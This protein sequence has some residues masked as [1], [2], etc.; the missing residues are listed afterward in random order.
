MARCPVCGARA[1]YDETECPGCGAELG[2]SLAVIEL[3]ESPPAPG[4]PRA[5]EPRSPR[6]RVGVVA[7]VIAAVLAV[8]AVVQAGGG[9]SRRPVRRAGGAARPVFEDA[10][11]VR[12][13]LGSSDGVHLVDLDTGRMRTISPAIP[14]PFD[15]I[16]ALT[17]GLV[18]A[19]GTVAVGCVGT[20]PH[21]CDVELGNAVNVY[22]GPEPD[23]VWAVR[24]TLD[25]RL[26]VA[27]LGLTGRTGPPIIVLR[28]RTTVAAA[29]DSGFVL[30]SGTTLSLWAR[31]VGERLV[32]TDAR[33]VAARGSLVAWLGRRC[34][35][36]GCPL[37]LT[38]LRANRD[39]VIN[40][41]AES[42]DA[43]SGG[44]FAPD[45]HTLAIVLDLHTGAQRMLALV[46]VDSGFVRLVG[47]LPLVASPD[48]RTLAWAP[49]GQVVFA[50]LVGERLAAIR[51]D[52]LVE[53][54]RVP[55]P[56]FVALAA[57][58]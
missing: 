8:A 30:V 49:S 3:D 55:L 53:L 58:G 22:A 23:L 1:S 39:R 2:D 47:P 35:A 14:G 25:E 45:L 26:E 16:V 48:A 21:A 18:I 9:S 44:Q 56:A 27:D 10:T 38:D 42:P 52:G 31:G 19:N 29:V 46:D 28:D 11:G 20:D 32:G 6:R 41:F 37:H 24:A 54:S 5:P 40:G 13:A 4:P 12:L 51:H 7:I 57:V 43:V 33:F 15:S 34:S 17:G 36:D 50:A